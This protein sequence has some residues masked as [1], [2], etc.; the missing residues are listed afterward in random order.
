MYLE[1]KVKRTPSKKA[2]EKN[3]RRYFQQDRFKK[4]F[5]GSF[6]EW[7]EGSSRH[8]FKNQWTFDAFVSN[9]HALIDAM[10]KDRTV[11]AIVEKAPSGSSDRGSHY[12]SVEFVNKTGKICKVWPGC[13]EI[14]R[15]IYMHENNRD[16]YIP[17]W[18][19]SSGAIGMSRQLDATD[20]LF[21]FTKKV[22][23]VYAQL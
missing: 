3:I 7:L 10:L 9:I 19:W 8:G 14:A 16:Q 1:T 2:I 15:A 6:D 17:K 18:L 12:F 5:G 4:T 23:G 22:A 20:S 21:M 11:R 13:S